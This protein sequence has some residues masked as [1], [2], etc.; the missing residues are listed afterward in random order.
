[1]IVVVKCAPSLPEPL[2]KKNKYAETGAI[3]GRRHKEGPAKKTTTTKKKNEAITC[4][5][6]TAPAKC[7]RGVAMV[8]N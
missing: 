3:S 8:I 4:Q 2:K 1:M 6:F 7:A 5:R